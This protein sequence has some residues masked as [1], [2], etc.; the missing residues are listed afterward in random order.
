MLL[1]A[2]SLQEVR[3]GLAVQGAAEGILRRV[4]GAGMKEARRDRGRVA[5]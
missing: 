4:L 2:R 3:D 5:L 1:S